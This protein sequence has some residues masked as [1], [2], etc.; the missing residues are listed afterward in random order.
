MNWFVQS[1]TYPVP[2]IHV[3]PPPEG[4]KLVSIPYDPP[5]SITGW[6][7]A[8]K[9]SQVALVHFHGNG[10]NLETI[11]HSGL[12]E[13]FLD[14][15]VSFLV[16]DY[17]GYGASDGKP[18]EVSLLQAATASVDYLSEQFPAQSIVICGWSLGA[19]VA[20]LTASGNPK[21]SDLIA[22]SAWTSLGDVALLH[23]PS[24]LIKMMPAEK[25]DSLRVA[26]SISCP[27]LFIHGE[28]DSLIPVEQGKEV[29]ASIPHLFQWLPIP[30]A[31][32]NDLLE[33]PEVWSSIEA[34]LKQS[35]KRRHL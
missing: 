6:L 29:A 13:R 32:H 9:D 5:N 1:T 12:L 31:E 8:D 30:E 21:I 33:Y 28:K 7:Y 27:A 23:F 25:Y 34:F 16:I 35:G 20:I 17:P 4:M 26:K 22:M 10:E 18:S 2:S 15:K 11:R 14:L 19:S 3:G 24:W